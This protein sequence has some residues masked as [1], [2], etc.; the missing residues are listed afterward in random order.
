MTL[1]VSS[2]DA[3]AEYYRTTA[4]GC[5]F[6]ALAPLAA[7]AANQGPLIHSLLQPSGLP[8]PKVPQG[9]QDIPAPNPLMAPVGLPTEKDRVRLQVCGVRPTHCDVVLSY[10]SHLPVSALS[11]HAST[12]GT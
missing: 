8:K 5:L 6:Q 12:T 11:V 7:K 3:K 2:A 10:G 9:S 4:E 1:D